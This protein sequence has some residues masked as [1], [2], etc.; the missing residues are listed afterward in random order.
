MT[1]AIQTVVAVLV[2]S[3]C[4]CRQ[5][6]GPGTAGGGGEASGEQQRV[7]LKGY[8]G[9]WRKDTPE[10]KGLAAPPVQKPYPQDAKLIDLIRPQDIKVGNAPLAKMISQRR[11]RREYTNESLTNEELSFL[12]WSTQGISKIE[13]GPDGKI[14]RVFRT[15]PSGGSKHPFETYLVV[16]RVDGIKPGLYRFLAVEHKLLPLREDANL[17]AEIAG[18]CYGQRMP[19]DAA[20]VF[21]WT[22]IPYRSEWHYGRIAAKL[23][24]VEAGHV[25]QNLYLAAESIGA[26]TCAIMGYNQ[27]K[28]DKLI[29][30]DG[31]DEFTVYLAPVGK[32]KAEVD[33]K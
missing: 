7:F 14:T 33:S 2:V 10:N 17:S 18:A 12:L 19:G 4:S 26:G 22:A 9:D 27:D 1:K 32:V 25:C 31:R 15:V 5:T 16:N 11:S 28:L 20:A 30:V 13:K 29:G 3:C 6:L 23:V 8:M 21:I 24:A